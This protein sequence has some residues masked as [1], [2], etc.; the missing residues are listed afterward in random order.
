ML[1]N[2]LKSNIFCRPPHG[3]AATAL[4]GGAHLQGVYGQRSQHCVHPLWT[5]SCVQGMCTIA[6]KVP[7]LQRLGQRHSANLPLLNKFVCHNEI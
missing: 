7:H 5:P 1:N 6:E 3:R 2:E 4:A